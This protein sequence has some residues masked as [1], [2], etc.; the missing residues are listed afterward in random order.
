M[1]VRG[2]LAVRLAGRTRAV[3]PTTLVEGLAR[4]V[5]TGSFHRWVE[6]EVVGEDEAR[7][8]VLAE[9]AGWQ[10]EDGAGVKEELSEGQRLSLIVRVHAQKEH[11][12]G[13]PGVEVEVIALPLPQAALDAAQLKARAERWLADRASCERVLARVQERVEQVVAEVEAAVRR[14]LPVES[15]ERAVGVGIA[16]GWEGAALAGLPAAAATWMGALGTAGDAG[17]WL[18]AVPPP[19]SDGGGVFDVSAGDA[20]GGT[21]G[22]GDA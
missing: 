9:L 6:A 10:V 7:R 17:A 22:G 5:V 13:R 4:L 14:A 12:R 21:F 2:Q 18:G 20:G 8:R 16:R 3:V 1:I 15:V 11:P 19:V